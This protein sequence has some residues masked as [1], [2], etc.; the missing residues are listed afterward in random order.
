LPRQGYGSC[1]GYGHC[2]CWAVKPAI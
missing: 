1:G 2:Y